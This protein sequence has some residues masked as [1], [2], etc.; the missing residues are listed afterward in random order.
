M[1][2]K[3]SPDK[4]N[5][6][7]NTTGVDGNS[8]CRN[9]EQTKDSHS[10]EISK[11]ADDT[12][13]A[14]NGLSQLNTENENTFRIA[15]EQENNNASKGKV[16]IKEAH[17][18]DLQNSKIPGTDF[19]DSAADKKTMDTEL[20]VTLPAVVSFTAGLRRKP[21]LLDWG[22]WNKL[23]LTL[24]GRDKI[25]KV[26]QYSA[27]FLAWWLLGSKQ[28]PRFEALKKSLATSRKAFRLGRTF[29]ELHNLKTLG[30]CQTILRHWKQMFLLLDE[31]DDQDNSSTRE[32]VTSSRTLLRRV[33]TNIGLN[34]P[35]T[36][37]M[38]QEMM[39]RMQ[40]SLLLRQ[41]SRMSSRIFRFSVGEAVGSNDKPLWHLGMAVIK[42]LGLAVYWS[43]DNLSFLAS[44]GLC[45]NL[46]LA[47]T[48]RL[49]Q[50]KRLET[51]AT[52]VGNRAYFLAAVVGLLMSWNNY[53]DFYVGTN[54]RL[55]EQAAPKDGKIDIDKEKE[56][57]F[58]LF[59]SL[60]KSCC[61]VLVF[62]NNPGID[63]WRT[64]LG[65]PL[66][67]G[68]HCAAGIVS[69]AT[70]LCANYPNA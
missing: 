62:S 23:S 35:N 24:D 12:S 30:F 51:E 46:S 28:A 31:Q 14:T 68:V 40:P 55:Q 50:R 53:H 32:Y 64:K 67:E 25:T 9:G 54:K 2:E 41:F 49:S 6:T 57:Q 34:Y 39:V 26:I 1:N 58:S 33:S 19:M 59:L 36:E 16:E 10:S 17:P 7:T 27:R 48:Q 45:D 11:D 13:R 18:I 56:K 43:G 21:S 44:T 52:K 60:V 37:G 42:L 22:A 8:D 3:K 66:N 15:S 47:E 63:L 38:V 29:I 4:V 20:R 70:V 61:D 69:A 65:F 5:Q